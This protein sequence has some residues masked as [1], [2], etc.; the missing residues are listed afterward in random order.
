MQRHNRPLFQCFKFA[1]LIWFFTIGQTAYSQTLPGAADAGRIN[2]LENGSIP[3]A[4]NGLPERPDV[5]VQVNI[6]EGS[7]NIRFVLKDLQIKGATAINKQK[8]AKFYEPYIGKNVSLETIW[9]IAGQITA[10]YR[11][12]GYF[13]SRAYVPA[14]EIADGRVIVNVVEGY[15]EDIELEGELSVHPVV[16]QLIQRLKSQ[17]PVSAYQLKSFM[18]QLNSLPGYEFKALVEPIATPE[19]DGIDSNAV[20]LSL[21][22]I[23][24]KGVGFVEVDNYGSRF[25]GPVQ[26]ALTYQDS[27]LPLQLTTLSTLA[28]VPTN[29]LKY[30]ALRHSVPVYPDWKVDLSGSYVTAEPGATLEDSDLTSNSVEMGVSVIWQPIRQW[31]ENLIVSATLNGQNTNGDVLDNNPLTRDRIRAVR[32]QLSYDKVDEWNGYNFLSFK[33]DQGLE[34]LGASTEGANNLSR[35]EAEADFTVAG[36]SYVRQQAVGGNFLLIGKAAGQ[37]ASAPLFSSEEFGY[38]GQDYGRAYDPSEITG[39]HGIALGLELRYLELDPWHNISLTP[40]GFYDIGK[41]WN[42][43]SDGETISASS[44]GSGLRLAHTT[45]ISADVGIAWPLTKS[46]NNPLYGNG[47]NPRFMLQLGY[48]F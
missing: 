24:T 18:L 4:P 46:V 32:T 31:Q 47:K 35:A 9:I 29:E 17:R 36:F 15:I 30:F 19:I 25:L 5:E 41:V 38:G 6:P 12:Q 43:D 45:G 33:L 39:D 22:S 16:Q 23:E 2:P 37:M 7:K 44:F 26:A 10:Y 48:S 40:Y 20:Q 8:L 28:S 14:Q 1:A 13:L 27:F 34:W 21:E 11:N 3:I 42:E